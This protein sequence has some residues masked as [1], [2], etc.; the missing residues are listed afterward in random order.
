MKRLALVVVAL[1][2]C[3]SS[4]SSVCSNDSICPAGTVCDPHNLCVLPD[5]LT[6]C[7]NKQ[8]ADACTFSGGSG[9]CLGGVCLPTTCGD[10]VVEVGE[11][12]DPTDGSPCSADCT[13]NLKCGN[14]VIDVDKGET[15]DDGNFL[16]NDGCSS[17]CIAELAHW[18]RHALNP[19]PRSQVGMTF[20]AARKRVI[21]F[22]GFVGV[23]ASGSSDTL[24]WVGSDWLLSPARTSPPSRSGAGIAY[25]AERRLTVLFGGFDGVFSMRDTWL[26]DG[27][28]W[29]APEVTGPDPRSNHVLVY[30]PKRKVTVM[31][32]G[33]GDE[34]GDHDDTWEWDGAKWTHVLTPSP[35]ARE[36][37]QAAFDSKHGVIV[38]TGGHNNGTYYADTWTYDGAWHDVTP[39]G[40]SPQIYGGAMAWDPSTQRVVLFGGIKMFTQ[41]ATV[42]TWDGTAWTAGTA[43]PMGART[44][45]AATNMGNRV[46]VFGGVSGP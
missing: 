12:C 6:A 42:Y 34:D 1:G 38:L 13:S 36:A 39:S 4:N 21:G 33:Y 41:V 26:W 3:I 14:G 25:D 22:A 28:D 7:D 18:V 29:R 24:E 40:V 30:D 43:M 8:E 20:D 10:G 11:M 45:L 32:G 15:C 19:G 16:D 46:M 44:G 2:G 23:G 5:Q 31:Y 35:P 9:H 17:S 37:A 27:Y